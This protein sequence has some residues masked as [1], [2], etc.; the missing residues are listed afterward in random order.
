MKKK[1]VTKKSIGAVVFASA[2]TMS[3]GMPALAA[4]NY[5][6]IDGTKTTT[7][8][9]YLVMDKQ[10]EVPNA[11]FTY[12]VTAGEAKTYNVADKKFE[13]L[14]GVDADKVTMAGVGSKTAN[15][16]A[17][18]QGDATSNDENALVKGYDKTTEKYAK[19]TATLDFS[20]CKF[21]EPGIYRY[22]VTESGT[23]QAVTNDAD[24]TRVVDVYVNDASDNTEYKLRIAGYVLH[25]NTNGAPNV[26]LGENNKS[27]GFTN[28]YDTS[29]I[30]IRKEVSG[31]QASRNK[32]FEFTVNIA[33][34]VPGTV[35]K[36]DLSNADATTQ[37]NAATIT[38]NEGKTNPATLT[39]GEDRTVTQKFY[40]AHGQEIKIQGIAKGSAYTV[41]EIAE[42]YKSTAAG[43]TNYTDATNGT[44]ASKDLKTSYLNTRDGVIPTGVIMAVAPFAAVTLLGGAGVV[45]MV[46]KK[47]KSSEEE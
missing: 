33:N 35:Y 26:S 14:A 18:S 13:I 15:T 17:Y 21:T 47:K 38:A 2:L 1:N 16:I 31:N 3:M 9:K 29:D 34:A 37:S 19:K 24:A 22:I 44:V 5:A 20:A 12:A 6:T 4:G 27:Q 40:L 7:F 36:V 10:A 32:Y 46:M 28:S 11:S 41:T 8:D 43:V 42:D 39:V 30:T 45:T 23:N 25:S